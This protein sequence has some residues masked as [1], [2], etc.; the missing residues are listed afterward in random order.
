MEID[1]RGLSCP[2]PIIRTKKAIKDN[3]K[4]IDVLVDQ[5]APLENVQRF[6]KAMKYN[7]TA[8][9]LNGEWKISATK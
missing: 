4:S 7:V 6:L 2:E 9:E 5:R 8:T 1:C 3:P